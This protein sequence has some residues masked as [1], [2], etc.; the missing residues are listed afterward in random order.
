MAEREARRENK[1]KYAVKK[2]IDRME[3]EALSKKI[4]VNLMLL[5]E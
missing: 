1:Q 2:I 5:D 4:L 3:E